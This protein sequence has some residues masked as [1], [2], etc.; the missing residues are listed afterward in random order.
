MRNG[1]EFIIY[2]PELPEVQLLSFLSTTD[3]QVVGTESLNCA[4][5]NKSLSEYMCGYKGARKKTLCRNVIQCFVE[6]L[7]EL[8]FFGRINYYAFINLD[9]TLQFI[10]H[11]FCH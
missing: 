4:L 9:E 6:N 10:H 7:F 2:E 8:V 11:L 5:K 1:S 3:P